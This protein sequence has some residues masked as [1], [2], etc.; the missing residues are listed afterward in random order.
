M[1]YRL[2]FTATLLYNNKPTTDTWAGD[3]PEDI[4]NL[5]KVMRDIQDEHNQNTQFSAL[6]EHPPFVSFAPIM[7]VHNQFIDK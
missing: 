6:R 1:A 5:L 4:P 2:T 3:Y 7:K